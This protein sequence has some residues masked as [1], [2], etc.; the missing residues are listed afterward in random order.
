MEKILEVVIIMALIQLLLIISFIITIYITKLFFLFKRDKRKAIRKKINDFLDSAI[1]SKVFLSKRMTKY[2][3]SHIYALLVILEQMED[4]YRQLP[5][6]NELRS[7]LSNK[8]L[9]PSAR[10]NTKSRKW[11]RRYTA[12]LC[13]AYGMDKQ[14]ETRLMKLMSDSTMLVA[15]NAVVAMKNH[16]SIKLVRETIR[17]LTKK[18]RR[19]SM[20]YSGMLG[21]GS[22]HLAELFFKEF[23]FCDDPDERIFCYKVLSELPAV[24]H[25]LPEMIT[26]VQS[27]QLDLKI[28]ALTYLAHINDSAG[29][30][31]V[32]QALNNQDW[33]VRAIAAKLI[34]NMGNESH[35]DALALKLHDNEWWVR[36]HTAQ[37]LTKLGEKGLAVLRSQS[38]E[39]DEFAYEVSQYF[40]RILSAAKRG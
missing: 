15:I 1:T 39:I 37:A 3:R 5:N 38:P 19:Q 13:F 27:D 35:I 9:K 32:K 36:V 14:D 29:N 23:S 26:D 24:G 33:E 22:V 20:I 34:G 40:L 7:Q 8:V 10:I 6:W 2:L 30:Q 21:K 12:T 31:I 18:P 11:F 4:E 16:P 28:A 17:L 25:I